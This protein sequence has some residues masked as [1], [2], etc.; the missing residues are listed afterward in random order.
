VE[1]DSAGR[2]RW[3]DAEVA[4]RCLYTH[5]A[6]ADAAWAFARLRPQASTIYTEPSPVGTWPDA[7]AVVDVRGSDDRIVSPAWA[8]AAVPARLGVDSIVIDGAGHSSMLSHPG[9]LTEILLD[10]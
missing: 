4:A 2:R 9:R 7:V 1:R 6:P 3:F 8:R 10:A 5:C